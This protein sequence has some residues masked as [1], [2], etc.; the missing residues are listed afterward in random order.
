MHYSLTDKSFLTTSTN[1][2]SRI[3]QNNKFSPQGKTKKKKKKKKK[4]SEKISDWRGAKQRDQDKT[5]G[6]TSN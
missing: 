4:K 5:Q 3:Y 1:I 2:I 6:S